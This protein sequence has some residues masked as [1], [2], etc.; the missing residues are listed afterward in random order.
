MLDLGKNRES[1]RFLVLAHR[2]GHPHIEQD[3]IDGLI[4]AQ[5][6]EALPAVRCENQFTGAEDP[7]KRRLHGSQIIVDDQNS[8]GHGRCSPS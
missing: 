1:F 2:R 8:G 5:A 7:A 6:Y 4:V 3:C